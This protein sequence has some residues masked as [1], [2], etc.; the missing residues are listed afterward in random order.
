MSITFISASSL[1][2]NINN[3]LLLPKIC[4][5]RIKYFPS[6]ENYLLSVS[7]KSNIPAIK[8]QKI[9]TQTLKPVD[10]S[11]SPL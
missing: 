3:I 2:P 9:K 10:N 6:L 11:F 1:A 5:K 4:N 7:H 8:L